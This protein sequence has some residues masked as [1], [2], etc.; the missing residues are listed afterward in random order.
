MSGHFRTWLVLAVILLPGALAAQVPAIAD[1]PE[2]LSAQLRLQFAGTK[3]SLI[4]RREQIKAQVAEQ[5]S[6]CAAVPE[7]SPQEQ[8]C[9]ASKAELQ[10][11][12]NQ[13]AADVRQFNDDVAAAI[14]MPQ[15]PPAKETPPIVSTNCVQRANEESA[16]SDLK[17]RVQTDQQIIRNF[18]FE[19]RADQI[20]AWAD[21]G[22]QAR[23][24]YED[25]ARGILT[26]IA[27][28]SIVGGLKAG[29]SAAPPISQE[30]S[31]RLLTM[32]KSA[33]L[34]HNDAAF[35][36]AQ[37]VGQTITPEEADILAGP[38]DN[39]KHAYDRTK[40]LKDLAI[41]QGGLELARS[42]LAVA[43]WRNPDFELLARDLDTVSLA[44][45]AIQ[46]KN[47]KYQID[48]LTQLTETELTELTHCTKTLRNDV[49]QL[50]DAVLA[51]KSLPSCDSSTMVKK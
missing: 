42:V 9:R 35:Q 2:D 48:K 34:P 14:A 19:Q 11:A 47:A 8:P 44:V 4:H 39:V 33:G 16:Y 50:N 3:V 26:D 41:S 21:L 49:A 10:N 23:K 36:I 7:G 40:D 29:V 46:Y 38:I 17:Q 1:I 5:K 45:Y 37:K 32:F 24:S 13:Y 15:P 51:L 18:G 20:E 28:D 25:K 22:E 27:L 43:G 12:I 31:N 30:L 6:N